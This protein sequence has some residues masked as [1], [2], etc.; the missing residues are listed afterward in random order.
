MDFAGVFSLVAIVVGFILLLPLIVG[1]IFLVV[2]VANRADPDP[3]GRRPAVVYAAATAFLTLF[4]TLFATTALIAWLCQLIGDNPQAGGPLG[5]DPFSDF[6]VSSS[7]HQH[8]LGDSVARGAVL[9]G[10]VAL[11]AGIVFLLHARAADRASS[12]VPAADPVARVRSSYIAAV[13]F[14]SVSII[15][16]AVVVVIYD[17]FLAIAPGVFSESGHSDRVDVL[18][19]MIPAIYLVIATVVILAAH[20]RH[21]PPPFQPGVFSRWYADRPATLPA[22]VTTPPPEPTATPTTDKPATPPRKRAPRKT[23]DG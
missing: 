12:G 20:L 3:S 15:V 13:S 5:G 18:R 6:S 2:V 21:A 19:S 17:V 14:V 8:P 11:V 9:S 22:P 10:I 23:S 4:V 16:V 1:G 7:A